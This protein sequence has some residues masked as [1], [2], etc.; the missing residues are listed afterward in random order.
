MNI[1]IKEDSNITVV[2]QD[3]ICHINCNDGNC[4]CYVV[5]GSRLHVLECDRHL[6]CRSSDIKMVTDSIEDI[7][8]YHSDA[9]KAFQ[10]SQTEPEPQPEPIEP[11]V[12]E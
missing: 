6:M 12:G 4:K 11:Q 2:D 1:N 3:D 10:D 9:L 5:A 7:M 8:L